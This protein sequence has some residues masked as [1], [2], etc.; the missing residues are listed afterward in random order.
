MD[1]MI[2]SL[3]TFLTDDRGT[4][5]VDWAVLSAAVVALSLATVTVLN[6]GVQTMVSR[7]DAELRTQQLSD[8]FVT[9]TSAH[10][11]ALY[12]HDLITPDV[13]QEV[14]ANANALMNHE[15]I[16]GLQDGIL[17]LEDGRLTEAD[18][19][20]LMALASVARQRNIIDDEII[21]YYFGGAGTNGRISALL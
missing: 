2:H 10:F 9:F 15:I 18:I 1:D 14:F 12:E 4:V 20:T 3:Q 17:A 5:S 11:E 6:G 8:S 16:D 13:A 19:P 21:D 7:M